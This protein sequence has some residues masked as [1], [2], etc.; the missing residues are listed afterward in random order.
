MA[1]TG[2]L[3][4]QPIATGKRRRRP[5]RWIA[6]G[7]AFVFGCGAAAVFAFGLVPGVPGIPAL[8]ALLKPS[9]RKKPDPAASGS[10]ASPSPTSVTP[11]GDAGA[12][13][14]SLE[15]LA[16]AWVGNGRELDAVLVGLAGQQDLEFRIKKTEQ[17][18]AQGYEVG[19][20]RFV[21]R[22]TSEPN[23]FAVEDR[24]RPVPP[25]G[26]TYDPHARG[27]CQEVWTAVGGDPLHAR[28]DGSRLSV[29]FAK[30]EPG[31]SNFTGDGAKIQSCVGLR[32]VKASKV[33][34]TLTR[35]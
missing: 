16:G 25:T 3:E 21:L 11:P 1:D 30:I 20:P 29:E 12:G 8:T 14:A 31:A 35:P 5:G 7:L 4:A 9:R 24:I 28:F 22:A 27:T 17:F 6:I 18:P 2:K 34:S 26:K 19:E 15:A 13:R 32:D 33:R 10:T 23:V